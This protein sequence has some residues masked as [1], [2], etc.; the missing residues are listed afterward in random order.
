[1]DVIFIVFQFSNSFPM[2]GHLGVSPGIVCIVPEIQGRFLF[3]LVW[4]QGAGG[5]I[6]KV[7]PGKRAS[8]KIAEQNKTWAS[9]TEWKLGSNRAEEQKSH[10]VKSHTIVGQKAVLE[11]FQN[12]MFV[13]DI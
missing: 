9:F 4:V 1:M 3:L 7:T 8:G 12:K 13:A 6:L 10:R 5:T 2:S 11:E